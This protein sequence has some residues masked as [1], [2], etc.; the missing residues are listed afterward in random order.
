MARNE[1]HIARYYLKRQA[2]LAA[3][4]RAQNVLETYPNTPSSE[5]ALYIMIVAYDALGLQDLKADTERVM[6]QNFPQS[7]FLEKG[8]NA[9]K[10]PWWKLW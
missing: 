5:E 6:A 3:V 1:I 9:Y 10:T 7:L 2:Y 4:N 8:M